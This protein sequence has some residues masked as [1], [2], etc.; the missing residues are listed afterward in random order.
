MAPG[1]DVAAW[2]MELNLEQYDAAFRDNAIDGEVLS[3][4]T[5]ADLQQLGV[6]LGHRKKMLN[7]I[8]QLRAGGRATPR[9][10]Q[11]AT[12][13]AKTEGERRQVTVLF[14]DLAGYTALSNELDSEEVHGLLS[15]F[16]SQVDRIIRD[17][18]GHVDK[19]IG[20]CVMEVFGAPVAHGNDAERAVLAALAI[21][22]AVSSQTTTAPRALKSHVGIAT[23]E[24]VASGTGS[25]IHREYTVT[26]ETV[27]LAARLTDKAGADEIL[28]SDGVSRTLGSKLQCHDAG[29]LAVKG[30][31]AP[32]RAY[33]LEGYRSDADTTLAP[34]VGRD[35]E[36]QQFIGILSA[37]HRTSE[38]CC[39]YIRGEAGVGKTRLIREFTREAVAAGF[40]CDVGLVLD[41]GVAIDAIRALVRSML[42]LAAGA[43]L[44]QRSMTVISA[45][46]QGLIARDDRVFLNDLLDVPQTGELYR[47][48][49]A[50]DNTARQQG[51]QR[52]L[53]ALVKVLSGRSPRML[54]IEDIHWADR[55]TRDSVAT[56]ANAVAECPA[57]LI[58][59]S[60]VDGDP[61]GN[62]WR[63]EVP[64]SSLVTVDLGALRRKEA[65][66]LARS[67]IGAEDAAIERLVDRSGGNPFFLEQLLRHSLRDAKDSVPGS[68][69]PLM[70]ARIDKLAPST[71]RALQTAS[72]LGQSFSPD[73]LVHLLDDAAFNCADLLASGLVK[74]LGEQYL[75]SHA[76]IRDAAYASLLRARRRE[77]HG[78]AAAW[79]ALRDL[80][81]RAEHLERAESPDAPVAYADAA[82][83]QSS[84]YR[85]EQALEL[86]TRGLALASKPDDTVC[87]RLLHAGI[88][89]E[90][91]RPLDA[92]Q[93]FREVARTAGDEAAKCR[94]WIGVASCDRLL[95]GRDAGLSALN[96]AGPIAQR[97]QLKK[98]LS[99]VN[100]YRGSLAF[101]AGD[102]GQC[103]AYH[104]QAHDFALLA[105]DGECEA[106]ALSGLGDA[107]YGGGRMHLAIDY[108][109]RCRTL[110]QER[111]YG[112]VEVGS[113]HMIGAI[114]RYLSE[115]QEALDDLRGAAARAAAV[116]NFRTQMVALNILG[117]ILVDAGQSDDAYTALQEALRLAE[118]VNNLRY[119][120]YILY[121]MGRGR[122]YDPARRAEAAV[123]L[124]EALALGRP[125]DMR[126]IGPRVL[127]MIA[128]T[129]NA[130]R[131]PALAEGQS[132]LQTGCLAHN[133]LWFY[134][135]AIEAHFKAGDLDQAKACT[136]ALAQFTRDDP[137]PWAQF[138]V[139]RARALADYA[140]GKLDEVLLEKL[141][142]LK[143]HGEKSGLTVA[144]PAINAALA[145]QD[146]PDLQ[147]TL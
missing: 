48:Y 81:L 50:M 36:L 86:T 33:R 88:L 96:E 143:S 110:S 14:A 82:E 114:R 122:H 54:V 117:E 57:I 125:S 58:M 106:R 147:S 95:G 63:D 97:L 142:E 38:G 7:A 60:R 128:L 103:L 102:I 43:S 22:A 104:S 127:A 111:G 28:I 145:G 9:R 130:R 105:R 119:R 12:A 17:H 136:V 30:F 20:D 67:I 76:L 32:V 46:E 146:F 90:L 144:L 47:L 68:I 2:L 85:Y 124:D 3:E 74:P 23:G 75:F 66:A 91:G 93:T 55:P 16:F 10:E 49:D 59:T 41:F 70:Q 99:E 72:I 83:R 123:Y 108:F 44:E 61:I 25:D 132:I 13:L 139:E 51:R 34:L 6:L 120:S 118:S 27:N 131:L 52:L 71:K 87:L 94:A 64:A 77:L 133:A 140:E 69:Q 35:R 141:R 29:E 11:P 80:T 79:Y 107:Q 84:L 56:L 113:T 15:D 45:V 109:R 137:L 92:L 8:A 24:V 73:A 26:G 78:R 53:A 40:V 42:G 37:C 21:R 65:F 89:R 62:Q 18:G 5:D 138:F 129:D 1:L 134:R 135:D 19:H 39:L 115:W 4:L 101:S 126:F 100:Y 116:N 121:E 98:E 112:R 31:A